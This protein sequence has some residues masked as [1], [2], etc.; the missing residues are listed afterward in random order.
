MQLHKLRSYVLPFAIA[1][2]LIFH[3][4]L[5]SVREIT[6][7]LIFTILLLNNVAV[8]MKKLKVTMLD[9]WI[10]VFQ[11]VVSLGSYF[12]FKAFGASE[13][14]AQ[15]VLVGVLCPVAASSVVIATMLGANRETVT[16]YTIV[17][18]LMVAIVAPI[19][20]SFIGTLQDLPF[21]DSV[22]LIFRR[23][24]PTI[25]L[26]FFAALFLQRF[27]PGVNDFL[28]RYKGLSFYLW[29]AAL[30][31]TLGQ[32]IDF[33]FLEGRHEKASILIMGIA[34]VVYCAIQFAVGKWLGSRYGDRIAGGQILAQKN[35]AMGIWIAN[36]Y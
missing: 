14:V 1:V 19:Y 21:L 7:Y 30:T 31:I 23:I 35:S 2:G 36:T 5:V 9:V 33:M 3:R 4:Q 24:A 15:G 17:G 10:M 29:A 32:T 18:N 34:S 22:W 27:L 11:I 25:A 28:C 6:P 20:F 12:L 8:D 26:P 16:T 13:L